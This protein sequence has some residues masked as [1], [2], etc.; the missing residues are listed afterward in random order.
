MSPPCFAA[1]GRKVS[2]RAMWINCGPYIS[3]AFHVFV[4][5]C[6]PFCMDSQFLTRSVSVWRRKYTTAQ[7]P[8]T[9]RALP[10][11]GGKR[12][13]RFP[14]DIVL[15]SVKERPFLF[16]RRLLELQLE[17][18]FSGWKMLHPWPRFDSVWFHEVLELLSV[19]VRTENGTSRMPTKITTFSRGCCFWQ[20][21]RFWFINLRPWSFE[22][23]LECSLVVDSAY[24]DVWTKFKN[25]W[26]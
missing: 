15:Q 7:I 14:T 13:H 17:T 24:H 26:T 11:L 16:R 6:D 9:R 22:D 19:F 12:E 23:V 20:I 2:D 1:Q 25:S 4:H 18:F 8:S 10:S 3:Q 5:Y 21:W